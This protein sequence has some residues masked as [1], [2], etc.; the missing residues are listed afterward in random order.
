MTKSEE[1]QSKYQ[2]IFVAA[3]TPMKEDYSLDLP[4]IRTCIEL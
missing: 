1:T 4:K 3:C 2:R